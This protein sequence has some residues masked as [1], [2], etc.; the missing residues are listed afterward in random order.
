MRALRE[1]PRLNVVMH[2]WIARIWSGVILSVNIDKIR[3]NAQ[4]RGELQWG[5]IYTF[6]SR[7]QFLLFKTTTLVCICRP[8]SQHSQVKD[9][10]G[11][12]FIIISSAWRGCWS[13]SREVG[14]LQEFGDLKTHCELVATFASAVTRGW[15]LDWIV[16]CMLVIQYGI[17]LI[18]G[19]WHASSCIKLFRVRS[20][21][22]RGFEDQLREQSNSTS[23]DSLGEFVHINQIVDA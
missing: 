3:S 21:V 18:G 12:D 6:S 13:D 20:V 23:P 17:S 19:E 10:P 5:D 14:E 9:A 7:G 8:T 2:G 4:T 1:R 15:Y 11:V 16:I 22:M